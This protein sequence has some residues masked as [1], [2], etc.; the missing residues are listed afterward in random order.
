MAD[1]LYVP[2][3]PRLDRVFNF[4]RAAALALPLFRATRCRRR[5]PTDDR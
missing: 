5:S 2:P 4:P 3:C 1:R